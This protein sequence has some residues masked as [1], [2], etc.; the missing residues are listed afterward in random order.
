MVEV[1]EIEEDIRSLVEHI[2]TVV[3]INTK[4][5][6]PLKDLCGRNS[7]YNI[8]TNTIGVNNI[9]KIVLVVGRYYET[10]N[11]TNKTNPIKI[12]EY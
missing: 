9:L 8:D 5:G 1:R 6:M 7:I 10:N 11:S 2:I 4:Q 12:I 3:I